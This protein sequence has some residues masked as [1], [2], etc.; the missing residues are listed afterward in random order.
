VPTKTNLG[1]GFEIIHKRR[2]G[3]GKSML[4]QVKEGVRSLLEV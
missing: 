3:G 1:K 2:K 4:Q